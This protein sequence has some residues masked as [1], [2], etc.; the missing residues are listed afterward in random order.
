MAHQTAA[1]WAGGIDGVVA[2]PTST[3]ALLGRNC[4]GDAARQ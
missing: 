2:K 3:P 4:S 1:Y